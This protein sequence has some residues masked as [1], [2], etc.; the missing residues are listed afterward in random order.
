[1]LNKKKKKKKY[2]GIA[3]CGVGCILGVITDLLDSRPVT[4]KQF[5]C[6]INWISKSILDNWPD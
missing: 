1:M 6:Y 3:D 2:T 5:Q 4:G